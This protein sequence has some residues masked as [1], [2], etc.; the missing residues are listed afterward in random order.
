M[1]FPMRRRKI[2]KN[3]GMLVVFTF[4]A[5]LHEYLLGATFQIVNLS[6]FF[7]IIMNL[8]VIIFQT[9]FKKVA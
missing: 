7:G 1:Y 6:A 3:V 5:V 2:D 9:K 4:S 8:P